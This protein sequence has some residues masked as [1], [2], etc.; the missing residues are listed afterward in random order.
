MKSKTY[1][2]IRT[3]VRVLFWSSLLLGIYT[4]ATHVNWVGDHYCWGTIEQCFLENK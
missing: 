4:V 2:R 3:G 1:Y